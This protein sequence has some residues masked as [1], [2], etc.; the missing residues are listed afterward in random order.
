MSNIV[1]I[2]GRPNVGKSTLFNRLIEK[3]QAITYDVAGT[4]RDRQ[5]GECMWNGIT[6]TVVDTG[7][8]SSGIVGEDNI[9]SR[10]N[11]QV[12]MVVQEATV[13]L[14]LVDCH[15][16][17]TYEDKD[18][19]NIL[20]QYNDRVILVSNKSDNFNYQYSSYEFMRLGFGEPICISANSGSGTGDMLDLVVKRLSTDDHVDNSFLPRFA[21]IGQP[22]VGK[23]SLL[24]V[25]VGQERSIVHDEAGTTRDS[26]DAVYSLY[27]NKFVLVDTAGIRAKS[28]YKDDIE[29]YS[30][31]RAISALTCCDVCL[32]VIDATLGIRAQDISLL[33]LA[34]RKKK[35]IVLLVNKWDLI[36]KDTF[37][38]DK[39]K[40][41]IKNKLKTM[42]YVPIL[43]VSALK[44]VNIFKAVQSGV[45]VY[46]NRQQR[47]STST[48]NK[49]M[50]PIILSHPPSSL[51]GQEIKIK[52]VTQLRSDSISIAFFCNRPDD[53]S[54][55]YRR[56]L[57]NK[58]R[59]N[60][61]LDGVPITIVCKGK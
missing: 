38:A 51:R 55:N 46:N 41:D 19:A 57:E 25:L 36:E 34:E 49:V 1:A 42:E 27:G 24:N 50:L 6:F 61:N 7:G 23:S 39:F 47:I 17:I 31:L 26:I 18:F 58:L 40:V 12:E 53:I 3:R 44:K 32:M 15:D 10:I 60:F 28:K 29:F 14:F 21:I 48:L 9:G 54:A 43:F 52:Y 37:T 5:Y 45:G 16:G 59:E 13:V 56:F 20:R 22:N 4:T 11:A 35:G 8:Y 2:V 33:S 30:S